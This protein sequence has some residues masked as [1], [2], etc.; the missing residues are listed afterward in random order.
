MYKDP[1]LL[2][3]GPIYKLFGKIKSFLAIRNIENEFVDFKSY[4]IDSQFRE[5]NEN[6]YK[7]YM[8]NDKVNMQ[9]SLSESM[10][11]WAIALRASKKQNPFLKDISE[12]K[13]LQ[14]RM[15]SES[16]HLLPEEQ[17]AQITVRLRGFDN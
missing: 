1:Y 11:S 10:F 14:S 13:Y 9:R 16:D 12:V 17:W 8:K 15:Y 7:A 3:G 4:N 2:N 6:V 5:I